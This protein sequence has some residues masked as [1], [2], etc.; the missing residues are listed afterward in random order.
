MAKSINCVSNGPNLAFLRKRSYLL[1]CV[2]SQMISMQHVKLPN[3]QIY[4]RKCHWE[5]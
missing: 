2:K 3:E 1:I 5:P 4:R